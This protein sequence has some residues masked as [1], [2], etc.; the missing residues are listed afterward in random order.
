MGLTERTNIY[1]VMKILTCTAAFFLVSVLTYISVWAQPGPHG[2]D[3]LKIFLI[4]TTEE[5]DIFKIPEQISQEYLLN[6]AEVKYYFGAF[7]YRQLYRMI[8]ERILN[9]ETV[10]QLNEFQTKYYPAE[11][12]EQIKLLTREKEIQANEIQR[13]ATLKKAFLGGFLLVSM[14]IILLIYTFRERLKN[15]RLLATNNEAIKEMYFRQQLCELEMKALRVQMNPHFIFNSMNSIN[16]MILS[17][18]SVDAS[19]YLSKFSRLIRLML[20][21]SEHPTV[22]LQDELDMLEVYIQLEALRFKDK[23]SYRISVDDFIEKEAIH[24]PS[25]VLQPFIEN[26]IWHG[27]MH[28]QG[29]GLINITISEED[30]LLRCVIEDNGVGREKALELQG[31]ALLKHKSMGLKITEERLRLLS[32]KEMRQL[33]RITDLKDSVHRASGTR[34]D[35]RIPIA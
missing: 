31:K 26:A 35:I 9:K 6:P 15:Q 4:T 30:D 33:I 2:I 34:V 18:D 7:S 32:K 22:T 29:E 23:I 25:M 1:P 5:A 28:K 10:L 13:Q 3:R 24:V 11:I 8:K 17:G 20:E 27:L 21:N 19:R 12:D 16:R 14:L